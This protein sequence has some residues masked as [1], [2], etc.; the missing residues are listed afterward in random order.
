MNNLIKYAFILENNF[1]CIKLIIV[2]Q[3]INSS[4]AT[5]LA[6]NLANDAMAESIVKT[7]VTKWTALKQIV[8]DIN[9]N[10][11][12]VHAYLYRGNGKF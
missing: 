10:A 2:H 8:T 11:T 3:L 12:T 7:S 4:A 6:Y 9:S 5:A 1:L